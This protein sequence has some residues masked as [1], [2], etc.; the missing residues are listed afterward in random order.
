[1]GEDS[2]HFAEILEW[3][4]GSVKIIYYGKF[5]FIYKGGTI[6]FIRQQ[7]PRQLRNQI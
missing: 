3:I 2:G 5:I 1:M 7:C 6:L 4:F